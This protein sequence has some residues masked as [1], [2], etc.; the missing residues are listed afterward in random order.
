MTHRLPRV[1]RSNAGRLLALSLLLIF[2]QPSLAQVAGSY[3]GDGRNPRPLTG[4][5]F[6]PVVL[7]LRGESTTPTLFRSRTMAG[8]VSK[9]LPSAT[10]FAAGQII[11]L[12]ADGFT[13]GSDAAANAL[14]V[15]FH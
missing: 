3:L 2:V 14:G 7:L 8:D 5:G 10:G 15:T 6:Q 13:V 9:T 4:M 12:D 11:S 1:T